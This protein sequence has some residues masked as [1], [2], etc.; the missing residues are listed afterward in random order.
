MDTQGRV[1]RLAHYEIMWWKAH[2]RR[3][4]EELIENMA[5]LFSLQFGIDY[6]KAKEAAMLRAE[7]TAWHDKAEECEDK[8][9]QVQAEIYWHKAEECIRRHFEIL[10][11]AG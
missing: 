4:K 8:D 9:Q 1:E 2:H 11:R 3:N 10:E 6:K 5:K 7:A